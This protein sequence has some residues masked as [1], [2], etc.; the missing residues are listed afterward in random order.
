VDATCFERVEHPQAL[1]YMTLKTQV[2]MSGDTAGYART[3]VVGSRT[4]F[5]I[6]SLR[7]S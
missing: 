7:C 6:A 3:N 4:S 5:V 1:K 2:K